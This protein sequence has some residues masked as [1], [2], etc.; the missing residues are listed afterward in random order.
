MK[1][2][3]LSTVRPFR[4]ILEEGGFLTASELQVVATLFPTMIVGIRFGCSDRK[5][6]YAK[7][8]S[9]VESEVLK[10]NPADYVRDY[11]LPCNGNSKKTWDAL[12][13]LDMTL[14]E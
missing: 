2:I 6:V 12:H 4:Q 3:N 5:A 11:F 13:A 8:V 10:A 14:D 1:N 7:E 9:S